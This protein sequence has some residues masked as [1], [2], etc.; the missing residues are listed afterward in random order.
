MPFRPVR[1]EKKDIEIDKILFRKSLRS[2]DCQIFI[3]CC[4]EQDQTGLTTSHPMLKYLNPF[5]SLYGIALHFSDYLFV[6]RPYVSL[7]SDLS[8]D[9]TL[10]LAEVAE[11]S[12]PKKE[13]SSPK[14]AHPR[15]AAPKSYGDTT[16][17]KSTFCL[18]L[19]SYLPFVDFFCRLLARI[20]DQV[21]IRRMERH[22]KEE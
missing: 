22:S 11:N 13:A 7:S 21:K 3:F 10:S 12:P 14:S 9:R 18:C 20:I 16:I 15:K 17:F 8:F 6:D 4:R 5:Q 1:E 19:M 2:Q